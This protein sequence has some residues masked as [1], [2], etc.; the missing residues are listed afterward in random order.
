M[1]GPASVELRQV[2]RHPQP[3]QLLYQLREIVD[4]RVYLQHGISI[5]PGAVVL[6]VG[7]N[8]GVAAAFFAAEC[9]AVV[10]SFEPVTPIYEILCANVEQFPSCTA[11]NVGL[12]ST[13]GVVPITYYPNADAMSGL[14]ADPVV[15]RAFTLACMRNLGMSAAAAEQA[16]EGRYDDPVALDV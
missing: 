14:Y 5:E 11:Y 9:G 8:V 1:S 16:L 3:M 12:S 7:A 15:D 4:E 6:D 13:V 10:H 2:L